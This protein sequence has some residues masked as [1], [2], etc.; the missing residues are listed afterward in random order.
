MRLGVCCL[1]L[2]GVA[3]SLTGLGAAAGSASFSDAAG[4]APAA[5]PDVTDVVVSNDDQGLVTF[6]VT[7]ANRTSLGP[8]D[9]VAVL[10]GTDDP[11]VLGGKREDGINFILLLDGSTG[12]ALLEWNGSDIQQLDPA[13]ASVAGSFSAGVATLTV[14]QEDLAPGFPDLSVP[15]QLDFAVLGIV[16]SGNNVVAQDDAP[17]TALWEY[18]LSEP[19]RVILTNFAVP[20]TVK[21]GK[22]LV[23]LMG[24]AHGDTGAAVTSGRI[25]CRA[26][27]GARAL[28]GRGRFITVSVR[29]PTGGTLQS[30]NATC[31]FKVPK[32]AKGKTVRGT[33]TLRESG[34]SNVRS[35]TTRVR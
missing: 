5:A 11:N 9:V 28:S 26:R 22:T 6:R 21:A 34:V 23:G 35:F 29:S 33:M 16:F 10:I 18:R 25:A 7:I 17:A 1:A 19:R 32:G 8:A 20:K 31:S 24:A 3:L 14:R 15:I 27:L 2:L 4:D 12:P 13:P 30:P